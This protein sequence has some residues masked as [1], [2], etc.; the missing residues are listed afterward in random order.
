MGPSKDKQQESSNHKQKILLVDDNW[1]VGNLACET[2]EHF[3]YQVD[4]RTDPME[5]LDH[6]Q[7][8][9]NSFDLVITDMTMPIM[10]GDRLALEIVKIRKNIPIV[11]CTGSNIDFSKE[12]AAQMGIKAV[13]MKPLIVNELKELLQ[14]I[15]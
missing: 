7:R 11:M 4:F 10:T 13:I 8:K 14:N 3:G 2:L 9:R 12:E 5:A 6:F 1:L 15:I